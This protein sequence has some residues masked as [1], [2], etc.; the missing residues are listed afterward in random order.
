MMHH[1]CLKDLT[2]SFNHTVVLKKKPTWIIPLAIT[3]FLLQKHHKNS[4]SDIKTLKIFMIVE[5]A[6]DSMKI[7]S[8]DAR[9]DNPHLQNCYLPSEI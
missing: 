2:M 8:R 5:S 9:C 7:K 1:S 4:F 3:L 6:C